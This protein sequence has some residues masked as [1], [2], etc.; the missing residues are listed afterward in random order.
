MKNYILYIVIVLLVLL[1]IGQFVYFYT[2][3][4]D[5]KRD[6]EIMKYKMDNSIEPYTT[7]SPTNT[8]ENK[9]KPQNTNQT[10]SGKE[11]WD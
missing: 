9:P 1:N 2:I 7:P 4:S 11:D 5:L 3:V 8:T 10:P 6:N